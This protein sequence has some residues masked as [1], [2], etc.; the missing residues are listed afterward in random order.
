[1]PKLTFFGPRE[2]DKEVMHAG[3]VRDVNLEVAHHP[4][5]SRSGNLLRS[6]R[7]T[8]VCCLFVERPTGV[9]DHDTKNVYIRV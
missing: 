5:W 4:A 6:A 2:R 7:S 8:R 9:G 1:M 3:L